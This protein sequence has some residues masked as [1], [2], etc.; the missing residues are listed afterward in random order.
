M[1]EIAIFTLNGCFHCTELKN[2]L[3]KQSIFFHDVE[4]TKNRKLWK[5]IID[6]TGDER[7]PTVFIPNN[8]Y[9]NGLVYTPGR[10][11]QDIDEIIEII[12]NNI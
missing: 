12:K 6:Q 2:K 9:G 5:K 4:I 11:F 1:K 3:R 8:K 7:V 10:D